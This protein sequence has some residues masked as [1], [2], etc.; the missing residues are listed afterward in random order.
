MGVADDG[1]EHGYDEESGYVEQA[2]SPLLSDSD[3][4]AEEARKGSSAIHPVFYILIWIAL[5]SGVIVFNK[6][7][8]DTFRYPITLTTWHLAFST[9]ATQ[10]LAKTTTLLDG[11]KRVK[12]TGRVY[13]RAVVPIGLCFSLSLV[14]CNETY[15]YLSLAFIQMLKAITPVAV[16]LA[17]WSLGLT[18]PNAKVLVTVTVIVVGVMISSYGEIRFVLVGFLLQSGG[19]VAEAM[20]LALMQYLLSSA[21]C[22]MDPLVSLYYFA[23]VCTAINVFFGIIME[24]ST[25]RLAD[26][27]D[28]GLWTL[29][30]N[31]FLAF[32]LNVS[33]VFL[34]GK[35]SSL[36]LCLCGIP[37]A[38]MLVVVSMI[39]FGTPVT[40][41]QFFGFGIATAGL[42]QY[43][44]LG[45][46]PKE[47]SRGEQAS[48]EKD[49]PSGSGAMLKTALTQIRK[50][51][52]I[53]LTAI[54]AFFFVGSILV[55]LLG[56]RS[57]S[58]SALSFS[59]GDHPESNFAFA[60][61][62]SA[63]GQA[64]QEL[65]E[66]DADIYFVAARVL[67]Y[68]LLHAP[69]TRTT[70]STP[71]LVLVTPDVSLGKRERLRLDGATVIVVQKLSSD[72]LVGGMPRWAD[73][74]AK[75]RLFQLVQYEKILYLDSDMIV[76]RPL[77][78]AFS[79]AAAQVQHSLN[80]TSSQFPA[81]EAESA[82]MPATYILAGVPEAYTTDHTWPLPSSTTYFNAGFFLLS[83]STALF[84]HYLA[85]LATP[86]LFESTFAE[87]SLLNHAHRHD[88][89][90][91]WQRFH[92]AWN[93]NF[94][95]TRDLDAGIASL[96]DKFWQPLDERLGAV[97]GGIRG[98]MEAFYA[99][100]DGGEREDE[101]EE[102]V[103]K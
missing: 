10:I 32:G 65:E 16:L 25:L 63:T 85:L 61:F 77:D 94:A 18:S 83:P 86:H 87:Q 59:G 58:M 21:E 27:T 41:L 9:I 15:L 1:V 93:V 100:K 79:D 68:Q 33:Q 7:I 4:N 8:L 42:V 45:Q 78:G 28:V 92:G 23:P 53:R 82:P 34:I 95:T 91:P 51:G 39:Y 43:T 98:E 37:K 69:E 31:A 89:P 90:M 66:D 74:L 97:W 76:T 56:G 80:L 67:G 50:L 52:A 2:P 103:A 46:R 48:V 71:F 64:N 38:I 47:A 102:E 55:I 5:S 54:S 57:T 73:L 60:T 22:S 88:G 72:W 14:L 75:M 17:T 44:R 62:L 35:T 99:R 12:M 26:L 30:A 70:V 96:H 36:V 3:T 6:T 29:L 19:V 49:G 81:G 101:E 24:S 40:V 11:R 84:E 13:F 20:R